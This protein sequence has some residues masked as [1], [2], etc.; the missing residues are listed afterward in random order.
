[1]NGHRTPAW[2][3]TLDGK[4]LSA[5][6]APR[7]QS[8]RITE[9]RSEDVDQLDIVI[10]DHD[11]QL[12]IPRKGVVLTVALGWLDSGLVE[13]GRFI[14]DEVEHSGAPDILTIRARSADMQEAMRVRKDR[15]FHGQTIG[16][17]VGA[18]AGDHG[19]A[20]RVGAVA[21]TVIDHIDQAAESDLHFLTRLGKRFDAVATV[22]SGHL[23][24]L[25]ARMSATASG[26]P[27]PTITIARTDGDR[28]R[29]QEAGR[30]SYSGVRAYW[31]DPKKAQRRSVIAGVS[32]NAKRLRDT[33]ASERDALDAA[34]AE[35]E[36]VQRGAATMSFTLAYGRADLAPQTSVRFTGMKPEISAT[37][38]IT[39]RAVHSVEDGGFTTALELETTDRADL[40]E[41]PPDTSVGKD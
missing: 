24:F 21:G 1:M 38:W 17:I 31:H 16:Q 19:L 15:S 11:G 20:A 5:K 7:L 18:I 32:G 37:T 26:T 25:P 28:H 27:L 23:L 8:L 33:Y 30:D 14:V 9:A 34:T 36:R 3:V 41:D 22:K 35:W 39:A 12:A 10:S 40:V 6:I 13:K 4:D 29:Y 2:R